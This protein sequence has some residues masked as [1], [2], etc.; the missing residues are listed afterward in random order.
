MNSKQVK[1]ADHFRH[2]MPL[3]FDSMLILFLSKNHLRFYILPILILGGLFGCTGR[4]GAVYESLK[5]GLLSQQSAV[6]NAILNPQ[7]RY[8]RAELA[9]RPALLVLGYIDENPHGNIESWY[10]ANQELI[11]IQSGRLAS[12]AGLDFDWTNVR[13]SEDI[14]LVQVLTV[15]LK[16]TLQLKSPPLGAYP[17]AETSSIGASTEA[18]KKSS[19][20]TY[21]RTRTV[22]PGYRAQIEELVFLEPLAEPPGEIPSGD[23]ARLN[24]MQIR[25]V[26]ERVRPKAVDIH[27]QGLDPLPAY[28]ALDVGS[29]PARVVYGRQCLVLN[30]CLS[31]QVWP[32]LRRGAL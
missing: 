22:M 18:L 6:D 3:F 24:G 11:Q 31:W 12:T 9:G 29:T 7:F 13:Y 4:Q 21:Q 8:L 10:T 19:A 20:I 2:L 26:Q 32:P 23:L 17:L 25:W 30:Y 14:P 1:I 16:A 27:N 5:V 28:Y 15:P